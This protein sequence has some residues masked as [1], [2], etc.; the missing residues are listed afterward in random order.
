MG[1]RGWRSNGVVTTRTVYGPHPYSEAALGMDALYA[2]DF[3]G[4]SPMDRREDN[5]ATN[6]TR[7]TGDLGPLQRF[8][9]LP[10]GTPGRIPVQPARLPATTGNAG[11]VNPIL[12]LIGNTNP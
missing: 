12:D 3:A 8:N 11:A 2:A 7:A 9:N 6:G 4:L 1:T 5:S 10:A